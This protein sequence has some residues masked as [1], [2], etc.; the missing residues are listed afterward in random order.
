MDSISKKETP[1]VMALG[2]RLTVE[3]KREYTE[4]IKKT[5]AA[6]ANTQG[7]TL[8]IGIEDDGSLSGVHDT[9]DVILRVCNAAR[10]GIKPDLSLFM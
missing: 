4:E 10:T 9:D 1:D 6:F 5:I 8:Y 3:F 2:E 7:G